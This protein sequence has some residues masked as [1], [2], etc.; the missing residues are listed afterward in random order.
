MSELIATVQAKFNRSG[1]IVDSFLTPN[2]KNMVASEE[3][4]EYI[5]TIHRKPMPPMAIRTAG[6]RLLAEYFNKI[7]NME[8]ADPDKYYIDSEMVACEKYRN[9]TTK[10]CVI[11]FLF[12]KR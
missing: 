1:K 8:L 12:K 4:L 2:A 7:T 3:L 10:K 9:G 5:N 11:N 6:E